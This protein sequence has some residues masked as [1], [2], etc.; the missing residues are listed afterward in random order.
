[1]LWAFVHKFSQLGRACYADD[2][3]TANGDERVVVRK[4]GMGER[5]V[6]GGVVVRK[7]GMRRKMVVRGMVVRKMVMRRKIMMREW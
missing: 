1:M 3:G 6:M 7:M 4:M 2:N 5:G